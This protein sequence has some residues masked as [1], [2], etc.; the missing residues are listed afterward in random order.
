MA[1]QETVLINFEVDYKELT[2]AQDQL[3]KTGKID[4]K[5]FNDIQKAITTTATDT[6][7]LIRQFK[8]VA[9]ASIK[10][11]KTMEEAFSGGITDALKEAGVTV[12]QFESALKKTNAP[13]ITLKKELAQLKEA[14]AR[15]KAEGKDTG[16][17]FD[18]LRARAGSLSDAIADTNAEIKNAGSDT[19]GIDNV[20]GSISA[21]A[22]GYSALQGATAL[23]GDESEDLQK[24]LLKVNSAMALATGI[25][26]VS[27]ALQKEGALLK[28]RDAI[29]T[30]AQTTAQKVYAFAVGTSTGAMRAFRIALLA[31]GI[32]A[33]IVLLGLA[34]EALGL[35]GTKSDDASQAQDDLKRSI[36]SVNDSLEV[37][38][39]ILLRRNSVE[40]ARLKSLGASQAAISKAT[41]KGIEDEIN[42]SIQKE[43][44]LRKLASLEK[45]GSEEQQ[46]LYKQAN[47]EFYKQE[48]LKAKI[49]IYGYEEDQRRREKDQELDKKR[50]EARKAALKKAAEEDKKN[51]TDYFN[52]VLKGFQDEEDAMRIHFEN[53]Q[54]ILNRDKQQRLADEKA[55]EE[56]RLAQMKS[57]TEGSVAEI[58]RRNAAEKAANDL[59]IANSQRYLALAQQ[60][61]SILG[62]IASIQTERDAQEIASRRKVV[63]E[64]LKAGAIT[65]KAAVAYQKRIDEWEKKARYQAAIRE[66]KA[67]VFQAVLAVPQAFLNGL[68]VGGPS[69][70][71]FAAL[72][73]AL[74]AAQAAII[75]AKPI[76]K[77]FRGKK[78]S[79][80]GPGIV[81]DMGTELVE[82]GGRMFLYTKPTETYLGANDKVY[83]A[84]ETR[85]I[86]HNT[87]INTTVRPQPNKEFD[88]DRLGKAIP[89]SSINI[90]IDK[91]FIS[92]SVSSGLAR[93]NYMDR[94]YSSK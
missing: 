46:A 77:F 16:K 80:E 66:K 84:A 82:R 29:A 6:K 73:A 14:L 79:Y 9:G 74:A 32:G 89:A 21:L 59:K 75:I 67:A 13:A 12:G 11:G 30:G 76:P 22:G 42:L 92:E 61:A 7:G 64:Q 85:Q 25:Q 38:A 17:E 28:L 69:A 55:W 10:M 60:T 27:N 45:A 53:E 34:A 37:Q 57:F 24:A 90:N 51:A 23:F 58:E 35:F 78:D 20:V 62:Q 19:R 71:I 26:Q 63:E 44:N 18:A 91:D 8:D 43:A 86:M 15:M 52:R 93:T 33:I 40:L 48:D 4:T 83:T 49:K 54:E 72:Y 2:N 36:E 3:A 94:R 39:G 65:E 70:P 5:G 47:D 68:S 1:V 50:A 87:N 31:T 41:I 81:G 88:Y 56:Q